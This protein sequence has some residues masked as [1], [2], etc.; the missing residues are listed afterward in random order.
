MATLSPVRG[1]QDI[2]PDEHR[3]YARVEETAR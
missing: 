2:L 3:L 1:T